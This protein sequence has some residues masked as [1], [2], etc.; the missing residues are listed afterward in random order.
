MLIWAGLL[1]FLILFCKIHLTVNYFF[2]NN[3]ELPLAQV[4]CFCG[5]PNHCLDFFAHIIAPPSL[6][7]D[8][9]GSPNYP[10]FCPILEYL[11]SLVVQSPMVWMLFAFQGF[12][13]WKLWLLSVVC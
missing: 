9:R 12:L 10:Q 2:L 11:Y 4:T 7:L 5:Y 13:C 1:S 6:R 8:S 3:G